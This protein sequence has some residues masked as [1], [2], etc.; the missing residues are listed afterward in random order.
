M[1]TKTRPSRTRKHHGPEGRTEPKICVSRGR[2][3]PSE[4][5]Y[6]KLAIRFSRLAAGSLLAASL[7]PLRL[8]LRLLLPAA[9]CCCLLLPAAACCCLLLPAAA[10]CSLLLPAAGAAAGGC[11]CCC[12]AAVVLLQSNSFHS[13]KQPLLLLCPQRHGP[14][15]R[16]N[17]M[18]LKDEW[19]PK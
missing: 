15:G 2:H 4:I 13:K 16:G 11:C 1:G 12:G 19:S 17:T 3:V 18:A 6:K 5:S 7:L 8:L 10:C 9:A 14:P